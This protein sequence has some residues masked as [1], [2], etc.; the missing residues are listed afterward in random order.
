MKYCNS[1]IYYFCLIFYLVWLNYNH[2]YII[3][4]NIIIKSYWY[5][6]TNI[7]AKF[8]ISF[9]YIKYIFNRNF[10][11]ESQK[12]KSANHAAPVKQKFF[13]LTVLVNGATHIIHHWE[14]GYGL[15]EV[16]IRSAGSRKTLIT[17]LKNTWGECECVCVCAY[18]LSNSRTIGLSSRLGL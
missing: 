11:L 12:I 6:I 17:L 15:K 10:L 8:S 7:L 13:G 2:H 5:I 1:N 4:I 9:L 14:A 18:R 16:V 3:I